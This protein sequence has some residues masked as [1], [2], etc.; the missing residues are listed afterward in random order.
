M[1]TSRT[2]GAIRGLGGLLGR[3]RPIRL[4]VPGLFWGGST[5]TSDKQVPFGR[6]LLLSHCVSVESLGLINVLIRFRG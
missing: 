2:I 6:N 5:G 4:G 1:G 3:L